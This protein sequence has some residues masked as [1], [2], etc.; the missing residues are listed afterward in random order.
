MNGERFDKITY[1]S[2]AVAADAASSK[3]IEQR[4]IIK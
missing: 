3:Y 1:F 4:L 2:P